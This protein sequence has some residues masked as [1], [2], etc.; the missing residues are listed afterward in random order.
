MLFLTFIAPDV[1]GSS[2]VQSSY[3]EPQRILEHDRR[4]YIAPEHGSAVYRCGCGFVVAVGADCWVYGRRFG[5]FFACAL[6]VAITY[7]LGWYTPVFAFMHAHLP[8]VVCRRPAD[9]TFLIGF[10][11]SVLAAFSLDIAAQSSLPLHGT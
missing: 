9:A 1:F 11:A 8:G 10:L 7:A 2:G 4:L 3:W 6:G 5:L